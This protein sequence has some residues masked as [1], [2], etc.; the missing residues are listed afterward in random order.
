MLERGFRLIGKPGALNHRLV[1]RLV[2]YSVPSA[3]AAAAG[4]K[5]PSFLL[6]RHHRRQESTSWCPAVAACSAPR[7]ARAREGDH[8]LSACRRYEAPSEGSP[9]PGTP[10]RAHARA[11]PAQPTA[12]QDAPSPRSGR[13]TAGGC[14]VRP[15]PS[16]PPTICDPEQRA[17]PGLPRRG[18]AVG[19]CQGAAGAG[20]GPGPSVRPRAWLGGLGLW[21]DGVRE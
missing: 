14:P 2:Q 16:R 9:A 10:V 3:A 5:P 11:S 12:C 4:R 19:G 8:A 18:G 15:C 7:H 20:G 6:L 21:R 17:G 1:R 13:A